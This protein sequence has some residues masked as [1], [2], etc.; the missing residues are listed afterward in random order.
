[1]DRRLQEELQRYQSY[2]QQGA[3]APPQQ[4][5]PFLGARPDYARLVGPA[6]YYAQLGGSPYAAR[7]Y[8]AYAGDAA[9]QQQQGQLAQLYAD[10]QRRQ[11]ARYAAYVAA[12]PRYP[13][14]IPYAGAA[15]RDPYAAPSTADLLFQQ[16]SAAAQYR[17]ARTAYPTATPSNTTPT[18]SPLK[19][20][21]KPKPKPPKLPSSANTV[22]KKVEVPKRKQEGNVIKEEESEL[23]Y[24][25]GC[26]PLGV[27]DDKYWLSELQVY[28]RAHFAE[29][30]AATEDDIAAPMHGRNK[31]I[32]LGQV[33]IRCMHCKSKYTEKLKCLFKT[34]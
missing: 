21:P 25:T 23:E 5:P 27:E 32:A 6:D 13:Y 31:P 15:N 26:V 4:Q 19:L 24:F 17:D 34:Q 28:L 29:A 1:M 8:D 12:E 18:T 2:R 14:G 9:Q 10:A 33:G 22:Y 20:P 3:T 11:V 7:P 30:F 16:Q